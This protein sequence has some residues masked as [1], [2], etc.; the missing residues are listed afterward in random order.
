MQ[1]FDDQMEDDRS[2]LAR[3]ALGDC[4]A[5]EMLSA[6]HHDSLAGFCRS[7]TST[8]EEADELFQDT[9]IAIW[10]CAG[11]F[12]GQSSVRTWL[13]GIARRKAR[14][15]RRRGRLSV[16]D[17]EIS[18]LLATP[19][20]GPE[21]LAIDGLSCDDL[22]RVIDTLSPLHREILFLTLFEGLSNEQLASQLEIP[23]GTVRSRLSL[24][25]QAL[26]NRLADEGIAP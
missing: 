4:D 20:P 25:R 10:Q 12:L 16:D 1:Q 5:L 2:L 3:I 23:P 6:R 13:F 7:L 9:Q 11:S 22:A 24:A 17:G 26:R 18:E 14:D 8:R 15:A 19:D 21:E